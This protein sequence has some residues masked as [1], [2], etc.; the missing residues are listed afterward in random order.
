MYIY[1]DKRVFDQTG[2]PLTNLN[3]ANVINIADLLTVG[4]SYTDKWI[5]ALKTIKGNL[6]ASANVVDRA[7]GGITSLEEA[8]VVDNITIFTIN[9]GFF[10]LALEEKYID[11]QQHKILSNYFNNQDDAMRNWLKANP[12]FLENALKSEDSKIQARAKNLIEKD[13][14]KLR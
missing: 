7:Q 3:G 11:I 2:T 1:N 10:D 13:L 4:S 12:L 8:G 14:Y 5:P 6:V 9:Q